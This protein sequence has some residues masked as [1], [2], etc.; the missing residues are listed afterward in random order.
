MTRVRRAPGLHETL[1]PFMDEFVVAIVEDSK[2]NKS[3]AKD[4]GYFRCV[5]GASSLC[6]KVGVRAIGDPAFGT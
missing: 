3:D 1:S 2:G 4:I 5:G 6:A